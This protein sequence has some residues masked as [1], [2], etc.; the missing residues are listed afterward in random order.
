MCADE[1]CDAPQLCSATSFTDDDGCAG[2]DSALSF[3][4]VAGTG[5]CAGVACAQAE[6]CV[7]A[8][9]CLASSF[10]ADAQCEA[11]PD[12]T[13]SLFT[14]TRTCAGTTCDQAECCAA[15]DQCSASSFSSDSECVA[16]TDR[17]LAI[18]TGT[19]TQCAGLACGQA[20]CCTAAQLCS[21]SWSDSLCAAGPDSTLLLFSSAGTCVGLGCAQAECC[22]WV[23]TITVDITIAK[24]ADQAGDATLQAAFITD[25][26]VGAAAGDA[27]TPGTALSFLSLLSYCLPPHSSPSAA[28]WCQSR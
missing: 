10:T 15:P 1:C 3:L 27:D 5:S 22:V 21:A 24:T 14:S 8:K 13:L 6:C 12:S 18:F 2:A 17:A 4:D 28:N 9:Q 23:A 25:Y 19:G 26:A 7:A 16:G 11:G 20:E